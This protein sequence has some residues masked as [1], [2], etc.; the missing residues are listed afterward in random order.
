MRVSFQSKVYCGI[1]VVAGAYNA[2]SNPVQW[3]TCFAL[4]VLI[5]TIETRLAHH[6][7]ADTHQ[8]TAEDRQFKKESVQ[9]CMPD[10]IAPLAQVMSAGLLSQRIKVHPRIAPFMGSMP[11]VA[12]TMLGVIAT[13]LVSLEVLRRKPDPY[14]QQLLRPIVL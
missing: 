9:S 8:D 6:F 13:R 1:C 10:H 7:I 14:I 5:G 11:Y 2:Y 4:G 12:A 3:I